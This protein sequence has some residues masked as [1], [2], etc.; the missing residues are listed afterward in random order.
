[1][2]RKPSHQ[3]NP[4][5]VVPAEEPEPADPDQQRTRSGR[6][7]RLPS[8][9]ALSAAT[10]EDELDVFLGLPGVADSHPSIRSR[11]GRA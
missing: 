4:Y 8:R 6:A 3:S 9:L 1:M 5:D 2:K 11:S 7:V 10:Y